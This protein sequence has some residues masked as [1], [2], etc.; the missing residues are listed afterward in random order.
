MKRGERVEPPADRLDNGCWL[1]LSQP[2]AACFDAKRCVE[3][4]L[5]IGGQGRRA[6]PD[7]YHIDQW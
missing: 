4:K 1:D 7:G 5:E 2:V 6:L 3:H